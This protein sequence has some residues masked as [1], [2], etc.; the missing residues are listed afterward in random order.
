MRF[1]VPGEKFWI[2]GIIRVFELYLFYEDNMN[3]IKIDLS[4]F[5]EA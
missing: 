3:I 4:I 5:S 2:L 1:C